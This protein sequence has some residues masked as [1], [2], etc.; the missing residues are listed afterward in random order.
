MD[1]AEWHGYVNDGALAAFAV[2]IVWA[3]WR[4]ANSVSNKVWPLVNRYVGSTE[5]L[6][7]ALK[8]N[9]DKQHELCMGHQRTING[10]S[11]S[12]SVNTGIQQEQCQHLRR[13]VDIHEKPGEVVSQSIAQ[14]EEMHRH[15]QKEKRVVLHMCEICRRVVHENFEDT[16]ESVD[17]LLRE[18]ERLIQDSGEVE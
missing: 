15:M 9:Q 2:F 4:A 11:E 17:P 13:L 12:V 10:L 5:E 7:N 14:T 8:E 6:H 18:V 3:L 16:A 1:P